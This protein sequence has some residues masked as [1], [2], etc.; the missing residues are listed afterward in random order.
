MTNEDYNIKIVKCCNK[1]LTNV[2]EKL[3]EYLGVTKLQSYFP[4]LNNYFDFY[5]GSKCDFTLKSRFRVTDI[6]EKLNHKID[7]SY[8]KNF[9]VCSVKDVSSG[10]D[11][12][13]NIFVKT[14]PLLN[15]THFLTNEYRLNSTCLPNHF[16]HNTINKIN[17]LNNSAYIDV[18]FSYLG[19]RLSERGKCPTF[20]I[21]YG[22]YS[23]IMADFK[24]DISE[25]Y[26][27][28]KEDEDFIHLLGNTFSL[29]DAKIEQEPL[30]NEELLQMDCDIEIDNF[31]TIIGDILDDSLIDELNS[32]DFGVD[33]D[34]V[35]DLNDT[36]LVI[37]KTTS[38]EN[39][40]K[41]VNEVVE[42]IINQAVIEAQQEKNEEN[43]EP[44]SSLIPER[45]LEIKHDNEKDNDSESTDYKDGVWEDISDSDPDSDSDSNS[46]S[47]SEEIYEDRD[48]HEYSIENL[49]SDGINDEIKTIDSDCSFSDISDSSTDSDS[50][51]YA[52]IPNFP[53]QLNLIESLDG[54]LDNY[55]DNS[56]NK[57][58]PPTEWKSILFQIC[59]GLAVA[60]KH[61]LFVHNDL[62]S[63]NIMF[64]KTEKKFLYYKFGNRY[65]KIPTFNKISKIIDFGRATFKVGSK[66]YFSDVFMKNEDAWGQY[67]YPNNSN[68]L[69]H[70]RVKPNMSFDL[71]RFA[72][73]IIDRFEFCDNNYDDI[74]NLVKHWMKD[75][76]GN[77]LSEL[78]EDFDLYKIIARNVKSAHPRSQLNKKIW[79]EFEITEDQIPSC[80]FVYRF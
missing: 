10:N 18:F 68:T 36:S 4:I 17:N 51:K 3:N 32:N 63:S 34:V 7:D 52:K 22:T 2:R 14:L 13:I 57:K 64:K 73:T 72:T 27:D 71:S 69:R 70:C 80:E 44:N 56:I 23:G 66:I 15:V 58:I 28:L 65:F 9:L 37:P 42:N 45:D 78:E 31:D 21:F 54:T 67:T 16:Y 19:S 24:I 11:K 6:I 39:L 48:R 33:V 1:S 74:K 79:N 61:Y 12:E 41:V 29:E 30:I 49:L 5:N 25:D 77:D 75:R 20:P 47:S 53:V 59:F 8:I 55:I 62:H 43:F 35:V 50:L 38:E 26:D 40:D 46:G 76:F 60:Q